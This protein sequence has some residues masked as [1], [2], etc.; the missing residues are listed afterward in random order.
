MKKAF[1]ALLAGALLCTMMVACKKE[2]PLA[3]GFTKQREVTAED[4]SLFETALGEE[5]ASYTPLSVATQVVAGTNYRFY[6]KSTTSKEHFY[7]TIF[8]SLDEKEAPAVT[9][10][11]AA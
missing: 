9:D 11:S 7:I 1:L 5:P 3:G 6:A 2:E 8:A 4:I 10:I